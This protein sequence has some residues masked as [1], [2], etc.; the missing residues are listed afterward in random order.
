MGNSKYLKRI[1]SEE[2]QI[3]K[4]RINE[5]ATGW[6]DVVNIFTA[7]GLTPWTN[8]Y[9]EKAFTYDD[10]DLGLT[11]FF[12]DGLAYIRPQSKET[13]WS[14]T[15]GG[16]KISVDGQVLD[17]DRVSSAVKKK[18]TKPTR[19]VAKTHEKISAIDKFQTIL[20]WVGIIPGFGDILDAI[21]AII[22]FARGKW[23]DGILSLVAII[24]VVGSGIK[25]SLKGAMQAA[26][27]AWK[28]SRMWKK[29]A[30][31]S[32]DDL[33]KFFEASIKNGTINKMQLAQLAKKGDEISKLLTSSKS[34]IK[35]H[36]AMVSTLGV[37]SKAAMNQI[38]DIIE[39]LRNTT[40]DPIKRT[41]FGRTKDAIKAAKLTNKG[42]RAGKFAFNFAANTATFGGF[43]AAK[44]LL[45][46]LGISKREMKYLKDAMDLRFAKKLQQSPTLA[47]AM[48]KENARLTSAGAA[49]IGIPPWLRARPMEEVRAWMNTLKET[50]PKKWK[51][52]ANAIATESA[53]SKNIH[54]TRFVENSFQ[55]A[56]NIFRPGTVFKAGVPEMFAKMMRLDSY[57]LSNPKN[58]DIVW[59]ELEDLAEKL[60][61]DPQDDPQGVIM[62]AIFMLFNEF[63]TETSDAVIGTAAGVGLTTLGTTDSAD[64]ATSSIP[65]GEVVEPV[66]D[67]GLSSIKSDFKNAPGTTT[68]KLQTLADQGWEEAQIFALKKALDIE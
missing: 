68:D 10:Q 23:V 24:P 1:I 58:L 67:D 59:N 20:D 2:Y 42:V 54:Y 15:S 27:G 12:E 49:G 18:T 51:A 21:N 38:D 32:S 7:A 16:T 62:P 44:N 11:D 29:A 37:D 66:E 40:T 4:Q 56:T 53:N 25:L 65:G 33:V 36:E 64:N 47:A 57:R 30:S 45:R 22:Y 8:R 61:L 3:A 46:K 50:D 19:V 39:K 63:I 52:V 26:G 31:G 41:L 60:G 48:L 14:V 34:Y 6:T 43:G 17:I 28:V 9:G 13:P 35:K 5:S 55:Q